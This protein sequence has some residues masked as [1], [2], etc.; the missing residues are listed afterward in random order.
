MQLSKLL[1]G[2]RQWLES[3]KSERLDRT[4]HGFFVKLRGRAPQGQRSESFKG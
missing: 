2:Y 4:H 1:A 3:P